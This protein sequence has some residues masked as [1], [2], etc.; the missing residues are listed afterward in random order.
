MSLRLG[1]G[2]NGLADQRLDDALACLADLGYDGVGPDPRPQAPRP[3]RP[4]PGPPGRPRSPA[5]STALGL[6]VI[7]ETGARY[8][9]DPRRKHGPTLLDAGPRA[10]GA[11]FLR[12]GGPR[13]AADLGAHAVSLLSAASARPRSPAEVAWDLLVGRLRPVL[14]AADAAGVPLGFEPEPGM[15]VRVP[16]RLPPAARARSARRTASASPWTSATA[17]AWSRRRCPTA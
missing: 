9:L 5:G 16:R 3:V 8:L 12:S 11:D 4:G 17:S 14:A 2:T 7:V 10:R 6:G 1:Y 13:S 15:L